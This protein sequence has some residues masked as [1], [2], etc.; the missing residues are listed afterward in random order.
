MS[1]TDFTLKSIGHVRIQETG[2]SLEIDEAFRPALVGLEGFSHINV[3]WWC[4]LADKE[5][6]RQTVVCE[7]LYRRA[8][9]TMG[10][11]A[12]RSPVRPNPIA[13]SIASLLQVD[14]EAGRVH[15]PHIDAEDGS[16]ILDIKPYHPSLDR[17]RDVSVPE[18]CAHWPQ[19]YEDSAQ[20]DW[21]A[22]FVNAL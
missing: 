20:F 10:V 4:H 1:E 17:L 12:T 15:I 7:H 8:P 14:V 22:E 18:W 9:A 19:W 3:L 5:D 2:Y 11:F 6:D 16:P 21:A 13:L